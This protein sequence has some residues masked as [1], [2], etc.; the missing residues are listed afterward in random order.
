MVILGQ[1]EVNKHY[2]IK[3]KLLNVNNDIQKLLQSCTYGGK[4]T[5]LTH[6]L[7]QNKI[8]SSQSLLGGNNSVFGKI[9]RCIHQLIDTDLKA[10][11][12]GNIVILS[13]LICVTQHSKTLAESNSLVMPTSYSSI[14]YPLLPLT[15]CS[16]LRLYSIQ[17]LTVDMIFM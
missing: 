1:N 2:A 9:N 14:T 13:L 15:P 12:I 4:H 5:F 16:T 8:S 10:G 3:R 6:V 7:L 17:F 11:K